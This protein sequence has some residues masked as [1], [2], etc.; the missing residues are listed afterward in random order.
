MQFI[1]ILCARLRQI[2]MQKYISRHV[3]FLYVR[4]NFLD[5]TPCPFEWNHSIKD[6]PNTTA[7]ARKK[8]ASWRRSSASPTAQFKYKVHF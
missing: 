6:V 4:K 7:K 5:P 8:M 1:K 3:H 2:F